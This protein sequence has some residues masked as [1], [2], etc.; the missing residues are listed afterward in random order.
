P[1]EGDWRTPLSLHHYL[2]AYANP[3]RFVDLNGYDAVD[4]LN[5]VA[6]SVTNLLFGGDLHPYD[7]YKDVQAWKASHPSRNWNSPRPEKVFQVDLRNWS[8]KREIVEGKTPTEQI[9]GI[10]TLGLPELGKSIG[11]FA[12][13]ANVAMDKDSSAVARSQA[14]YD[15]GS[16]GV[17]VGIAV[18]QVALTKRSPPAGGKTRVPSANPELAKAPGSPATVAAERAEITTVE[19]HGRAGSK[20]GEKA[21]SSRT[22]EA[23]V[24]RVNCD[25]CFIA[26][27][28]VA[29]KDGFK[30]IED[31]REGDLVLSKSD[32]TGEI[33]YKPVTALI[34]TRNKGVYD[35]TLR[36]SAGETEVLTVTD[37]HPFWVLNKDQYVGGAVGAGWVESGQLKAGMLVQSSQ[38]VELAVES[39]MDKQQSPETYNL[40]VDGF[41]TYFVGKFRVWVHNVNCFDADGNVVGG[42]P[43]SVTEAKSALG[44]NVVIRVNSNGTATIHVGPHIVG[45]YRKVDG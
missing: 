42:N 35:L 28:L 3:A 9:G 39:L 21:A 25:S 20:A 23:K 31:V 1:Y 18:A 12:G 14:H 33:A 41:H 8:L 38:G 11:T 6:T 4:T 26:G 19:A 2:Y 43:S 45:P 17:G 7:D 27:T 40:T 22:A 36:N 30:A 10:L 34:A 24:R 5:G 37:N 15:L 16:N 44:E 32:V 29:V 13:A